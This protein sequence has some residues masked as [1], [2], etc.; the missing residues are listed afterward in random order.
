MASDVSMAMK[1]AIIL[2]LTGALL[3]T[4]LTVSVPMTRWLINETGKTVIITDITYNQ[5]KGTK[6]MDMNAGRIYRYYME[7][8]DKIACIAV[9]EHPITSPADY[10][11]LM[12]K[13]RTAV[14]PALQDKI[15]VL[16]WSD[17]DRGNKEYMIA[18]T[19][20][21]HDMISKDFRVTVNV[22]PDGG[23]ELIC[24]LTDEFYD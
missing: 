6:G 5:L 23:L 4:V 14:T 16:D 13:E 7:T 11:V 21:N 8:E 24:D 9:R 22:F 15:D 17:P 10:K 18:S 12:C 1:I 19:Y 2:L 20:F 3:S